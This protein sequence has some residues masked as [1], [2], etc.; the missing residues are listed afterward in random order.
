VEFVLLFYRIVLLE[1]ECVCVF[2]CSNILVTFLFRRRGSSLVVK[3]IYIFKDFSV[4][5]NNK[6]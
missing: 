6:Q 2:E 4:T 3:Y 5:V 1:Q